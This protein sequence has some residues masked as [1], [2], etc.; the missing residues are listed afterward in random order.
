MKKLTLLFVAIV[1]CTLVT[2]QTTRDVI[3]LK[4]G[5]VI[6]GAIIEQYPDSILK[7][8]LTDGSI[9]VYKTNE[10]EKML[11][12][13][14][15]ATPVKEKPNTKE[16]GGHLGLGVAIGGGGILGVPLR[17]GLSNMFALEAGVFLRPSYYYTKTRKTTTVYDQYGNV[18]YQ[19][20]DENE[21]EKFACPPMIAGGLNIFF[22]ENYNERSG[23]IVRNGLAIK[24]GHTIISDYTENMFAI[25]WARERFKEHRK[26]Q[27]YNMELGLG[28]LSYG[29]GNSPLGDAIDEDLPILPFIYYKFHWNWYVV[30]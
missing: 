15:A 16:Y 6:K 29:D 11:R 10:V 8:K 19:Y 3:H 26:R 12:E 18:V 14:V 21:S 1:T 5:S 28:I 27:S 13:E 7:I 17:V 30:K 2:A 25:G 23:K 20:Y 4:N 24:A 22:G 9:M